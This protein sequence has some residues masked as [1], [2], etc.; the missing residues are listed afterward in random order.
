MQGSAYIV[1]CR[2]SIQP[3]NLTSLQSD[4][5]SLQEALRMQQGLPWKSSSQATIKQLT[6]LTMSTDDSSA[7]AQS[8]NGAHG[9]ASS[10]D[11]LAVQPMSER[12]LQQV[13]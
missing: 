9:A 11:L 4:S 12:V 13:C 7:A 8:L 5:Y 3:L 1:A 10:Y 6:R 2:C